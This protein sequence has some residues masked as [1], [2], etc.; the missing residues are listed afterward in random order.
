[1][2][3][4]R[5]QTL[6]GAAALVSGAGVQTAIGQDDSPPLAFVEVAAEAE[7]VIIANVSGETFDL[8]GYSINFEVGQEVDQVSEFTDGT[9]I[10]AGGQLKI[11]TGYKDVEDADVTFDYTGNGAIRNDGSD[12]VGIIDSEGEIVIRH[13]N[14]AHW[15]NAIDDGGDGGDDGDDGTDGGA[16]DGTDDDDNGTGDGTDDGD[17]D[18]T[19]DG[20]DGEPDDD[21]DGGTDDGTDGDNDE[22]DG[23]DGT[24]GDNDSDETPDDDC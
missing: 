17:D 3:P 4:T 12:V 15:I 18:G 1:M 10:E 21:D 9:A 22:T 5:R 16:D 23:D 19:D 13:N 2:A 20:D 8:T 24:D 11:A 6:V 14:D 7:Y